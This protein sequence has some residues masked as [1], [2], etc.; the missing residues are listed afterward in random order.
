M[1]EAIPVR[2][3]SARRARQRRALA[4]ID[5]ARLLLLSLSLKALPMSPNA[6]QMTRGNGSI[7]PI[8]RLF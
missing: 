7:Y 5:Q 6:V 4:C 1:V 3:T 2:P 8:G